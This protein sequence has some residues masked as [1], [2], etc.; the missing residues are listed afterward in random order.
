MAVRLFC[1]QE[2][3][4]SSPVGGLLSIPAMKT[5][6]KHAKKTAKKTVKLPAKKRAAKPAAKPK[7]YDI[8]TDTA[9]TV[10]RHSVQLPEPDFKTSAAALTYAKQLKEY[11]ET[12]LA[13]YPKTPS[14]QQ[15]IYQAERIIKRHSFT[16]QTIT[17]NGE[18]Y[19]VLTAERTSLNTV[20]IKAVATTRLPTPSP[21]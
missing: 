11:S 21:F 4:G 7:L 10:S 3:A 8:K 15:L 6:K 5:K 9:G 1:K 2:A 16:P 12:L 20:C 13:L 18:L 14:L 17:Y 19:T